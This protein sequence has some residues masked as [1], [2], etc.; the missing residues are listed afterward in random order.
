MASKYDKIKTARDLVIDAKYH[1]F[2]TK[3]EDVIRAQDIF[4]HSTIE[5]LDALANDIG[6]NNENGEPD[7]KG[8]WSSDRIPTRDTFYSILFRIWNWEDATRFWNQH[9]NPEREQIAVVRI[10]NQTQ[11]AEIND[12]ARRIEKYQQEVDLMEERLA[13]YDKV[14]TERLNKINELSAAARE[15]DDEIMRLKAKLYDLLTK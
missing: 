1:G 11:R 4:G 2:S 15:K 14:C 12:K 13:E 7:P 10:E 8:T 3:Q 5:E 6:R 9:S